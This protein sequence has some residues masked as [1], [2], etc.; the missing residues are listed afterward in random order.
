MKT[1][2][3]F[4]RLDFTK[5]GIDPK[6]FPRERLFYWLVQPRIPVVASDNPLVTLFIRGMLS[7]EK[8]TFVY[9]GGSM[10]GAPRTINV[11]LVFRHPTES[12][13]Y[14]AGYCHSRAANRIFRIDLAMIF[15]K[16]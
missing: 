11:S 12:G 3:N 5:P 16:V 4:L 14:I 7:G 2:P 10:P 1:G 6:L 9:A 8:V 13:I 15:Q